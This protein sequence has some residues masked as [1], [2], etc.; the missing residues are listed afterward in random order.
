M[1]YIFYIFDLSLVTHQKIPLASL[2]EN[3]SLMHMFCYK[4]SHKEEI[5]KSSEF[6]VK[7]VSRMK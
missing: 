1:Q 6:N 7:S 3:R 4:I 2:N 5:I